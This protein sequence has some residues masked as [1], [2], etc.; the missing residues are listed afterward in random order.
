[1]IDL[2]SNKEINLIINTP[3]RT[4]WQTDEG[5]IRASA[6]R[7]GVPMLTTATAAAV[8]VRA[9]EALRAGDWGVAA[10]QDYA[11]TRPALLPPAVTVGRR[12]VL[13]DERP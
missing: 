3:T 6:V 4:G 8:A 11:R 12:P 2:M 13:A 5:K 7:L 1:V 9:I 10:L